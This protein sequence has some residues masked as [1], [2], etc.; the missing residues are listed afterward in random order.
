MKVFSIRKLMSRFRSDLGRYERGPLTSVKRDFRYVLAIATLVLVLTAVFHYGYYADVIATPEP[1]DITTYPDIKT[2]ALK[3][4]VVKY[5]ERKAFF[6][7][8][9]AERPGRD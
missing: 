4:I 9:I 8:I 5:A 1:N 6:E 7:K 3:G 2:S